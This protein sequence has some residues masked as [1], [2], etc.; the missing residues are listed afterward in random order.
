MG[1]GHGFQLDGAVFIGGR[2]KR[3]MRHAAVSMGHAGMEH[4]DG[5]EHEAIWWL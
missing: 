5:S 4:G 1:R 3:S 2:L